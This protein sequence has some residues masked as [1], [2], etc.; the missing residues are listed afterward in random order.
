[1]GIDI[2]SPCARHYMQINA[3]CERN[4]EEFESFEKLNTWCRR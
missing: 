3:S 1:M 4:W 2:G